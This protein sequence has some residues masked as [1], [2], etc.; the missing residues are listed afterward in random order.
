MIRDVP[1]GMG[2]IRSSRTFRKGK[3]RKLAFQGK[4][5]YTSFV[6]LCHALTFLILLRSAPSSCVTWSSL[7]LFY[8]EKNGSSER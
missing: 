2:L 3:N 5:L 8:R 7:S 6:V 4:P 1:L